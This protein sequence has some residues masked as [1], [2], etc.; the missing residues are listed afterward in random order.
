[1]HNFRVT[2][3]M[4]TDSTTRAYENLLRVP[5][6]L[7]A[8]LTIC[9]HVYILRFEFVTIVQLKRPSL[10]AVRGRNSYISVANRS[11]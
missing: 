2:L 11:I 5:H 4:A 1:M 8:D 9:R 7:I 6:E 10:S 3:L